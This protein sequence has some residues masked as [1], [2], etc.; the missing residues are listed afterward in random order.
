MV[1]PE[2]DAILRSR[3]VANG[4]SV[5]KEMVFLMETA[6]GVSSESVRE[7]IHLLYK[8]GV[9]VTEEATPPPA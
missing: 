7:T 8:A 2:L 3:A 1:S 9:E 4:R 6:L 5:T